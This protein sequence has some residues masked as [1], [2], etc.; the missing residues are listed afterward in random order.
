V[1]SPT[2]A[3]RRLVAAA[4]AILALSA[5]C[6]G[7]ST[8]LKG[9]IRDDKIVLAADH[10]GSAVRF[11][12]HNSGTMACDIVLVLTSL[13]ADALPVKDGMVVIVNGDGPGIVR[14]DTTY[15]SQEPYT[16][17]RVLPGADF[18]REIAMEGA[19]KV[20]DRVILC[21]G[22]GDYEH[23]RFAPLRFDR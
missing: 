19:P 5:G 23:G 13:K 12:L 20:E 10:A 11:E 22:V 18:S 4:F 3:P 14:P 15:E 1:K 21:N 16:L 9:E 2:T 7:G 8:A 6:I 17:G